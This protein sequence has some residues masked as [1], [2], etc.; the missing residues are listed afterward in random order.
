MVFL[1]VFFKLVV[2]VTKNDKSTEHFEGPDPKPGCEHEGTKVSWLD[3]MGTKRSM[4]FPL[5]SAQKP[6]NGL[7]IMRIIFSCLVG[8]SI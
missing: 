6:K 2:K 5:L 4:T 3:L 1:W 8:T 7:K